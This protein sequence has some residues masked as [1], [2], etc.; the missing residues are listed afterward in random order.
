LGNITSDGVVNVLKTADAPT[1][2]EAGVYT[3][4]CLHF[5]VTTADAS[6]AA[7]QLY[8]VEQRIEGYNVAS[9]GSGKAGTRYV[10][11]SFWVK[12]TKTGIFC[13]AFRNYNATRSYISEYTINVTNTWEKKV[14][15]IAVD[16]A[17]TWLYDNGIGFIVMWAIACGS[18][19]QT[20]AG[21]WT[22]GNYLATANQVNALDNVANDFKLALVQLEAGSTATTFEQ[23]PYSV[24]LAMCQRYYEKSYSIDVAPGTASVNTY[25]KSLIYDA[26]RSTSPQIQFCVPKRAIPTITS[27]TYAGASGSFTE[28]DGGGGF[29]NRTPTVNAMQNGFNYTSAGMTVGYNIVYNWTASS[30]L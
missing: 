19:F 8:A 25:H 1:A 27:Y 26:A 18:T 3:E 9:F 5:D 12:S 2:A 13:V 10:T 4:H 6:I 23:R 7:G 14:I 22:A 17:G 15:T 29:I 24:E 30:E 11:L 20:A 28:W 21:A 16:T